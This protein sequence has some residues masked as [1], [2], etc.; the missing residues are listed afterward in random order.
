MLN[1][2]VLHTVITRILVCVAYRV[3][4]ILITRKN[5]ITEERRESLQELVFS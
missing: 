1:I 5:R 4:N 3:L 2:S